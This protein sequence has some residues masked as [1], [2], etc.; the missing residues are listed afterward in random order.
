M[1]E[2]APVTIAQGPNVCVSMRLIEYSSD[3]SFDF[4]ALAMHFISR[5]NPLYPEGTT[6]RIERQW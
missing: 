1:P 3:L 5:W 6:G 2:D 4:S